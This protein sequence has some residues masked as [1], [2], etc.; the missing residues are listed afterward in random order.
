MKIDIDMK[1]DDFQQLEA[2]IVAKYASVSQKA[3]PKKAVKI[4]KQI[5]DFAI[6]FSSAYQKFKELFLIAHYQRGMYLAFANIKPDNLTYFAA[7]DDLSKSYN[8]LVD[9][10]RPLWIHLTL[11]IFDALLVNLRKLIID[12]S[13]GAGKAI[14]MKNIVTQI[15][16]LHTNIKADSEEFKLFLQRLD[17]H[18]DR[19]E[20]PQMQNLWDY[21]YSNVVHLDDKYKYDDSNSFI[22][23]NLRTLIDT[24]N[25]FMVDICEFYNYSE[26]GH[27]LNTSYGDAVRWMC[28]LGFFIENSLRNVKDDINAIA[29]A[30]YLHPDYINLTPEEASSKILKKAI[31]SDEFLSLRMS[32]ELELTQ[33][34]AELRDEFLRQN[35]GN[36]FPNN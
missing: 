29:F 3:T 30:Y 10:D 24:V 5:Q 31:P 11:S 12:K 18:I 23:S 16:N 35:T 17:S 19:A 25:D 33:R 15:R 14:S 6:N 20:S 2:S 26:S 1:S 34:I 13:S 9:L 21:T 8:E 32:I 4:D 28:A 22:I 27:L 7:E 36:R